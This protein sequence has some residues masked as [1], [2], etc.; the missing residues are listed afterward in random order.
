ML[1]RVIAILF[2]TSSFASGQGAQGVLRKSEALKLTESQQ[3]QIRAVLSKTAK[4]YNEL[5]SQGKG[6]PGL[7]RKLNALREGA[8]KEALKFL[9][10]EQ[11]TTWDQLNPGILPAPVENRAT[12]SP[13]RDGSLIIPTIDELKR[14]PSPGAFGPSTTLARTVPHQVSSTGYLILTDHTDQTA[15]TALEQLAEARGGELMALKSLG[16]LHKDARKVELLQDA[17]REV[18]PRFVAIAPM[19]ESYRENM[20]LCLLRILSGL[21]KDP[22]LDVFPGYLIASSP[23]QLAELIE[24]TIQFR[25]R[26]VD[27]IRPV[28]M[29]AIEDSDARRYRSYQKAKVMQ[30]MFAE[31]GKQSPAIIVTTKKSH[32]ERGD[33]PELP[34]GEGNIVMSPT[35]QRHTFKSLSLPAELAIDESNMLFMF[36]HGTTNRI[37]GI[38]INAFAKID[39]GGGII[40]CGSCMS[41]APYDADRV[42]LT[43]KRDDKRFA[44]HAMDNGAVAML[45]HM[46]LCGGFPKVFPMAEQVLAGT[47]TGEAYQQLMNSIIGDKAIPDYYRGHDG[48]TGPANAY[49]YVL[50]G[51]PSLI[52]VKK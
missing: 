50:L 9:T 16:T 35:S 25:P 19:M 38:H 21:D 47:S 41:A 1:L 23:A 12:T 39:F 34:A 29:G 10:E 45:G 43:S 26:E 42:D 36:G 22:E 7:N 37:C 40:F 8:E 30:K 17:I 31:E 3:Q 11:R 33:Y 4:E 52:P 20:H 46:G 28:S 48:P 44:F 13:P 2:L 18:N 27:E 32:M 15:V 49:L 5:R 24:Q 14:P 6:D 51:D